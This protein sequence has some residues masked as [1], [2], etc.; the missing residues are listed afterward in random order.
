MLKIKQTDSYVWVFE[1]NKKVPRLLR[2]EESEQC[3]SSTNQHT[4]LYNT[5][6]CIIVCLCSYKCL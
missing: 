4:V 1:I 6:L 5:S 2:T 3:D